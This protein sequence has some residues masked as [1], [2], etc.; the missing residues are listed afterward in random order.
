[1]V[2]LPVR[3]AHPARYNMYSNMQKNLIL[4]LDN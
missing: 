1:M 3:T 4:F 2:Y